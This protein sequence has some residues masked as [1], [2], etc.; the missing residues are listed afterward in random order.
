MSDDFNLDD[1]AP[2]PKSTSARKGLMTPKPEQV[3]KIYNVD[4]VPKD[5][6]KS[7]TLKVPQADSSSAVTYDQLGLRAP[8]IDVNKFKQLAKKRRLSQPQLLR[9]LLLAYEQNSNVD[10]IED[11]VVETW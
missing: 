2:K 1:F 3:E 5:A 9:V 8:S 4:R 11:Q 10:S 7:K 6:E